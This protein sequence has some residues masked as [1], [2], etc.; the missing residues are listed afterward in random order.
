MTEILPSVIF[1]SEESGA[2]LFFA[3][4]NLIQSLV[5]HAGLRALRTPSGLYRRDI[6]A[7]ER[8]VQ[9]AWRLLRWRNNG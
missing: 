4:T 7:T 5:P 2:V 3:L 9:R 1:L 6:N 8:Q